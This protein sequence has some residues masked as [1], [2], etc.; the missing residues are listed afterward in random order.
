[1][2]SMVIYGTVRQRYIWWRCKHCTKK[3]Y[4]SYSKTPPQKLNVREC[5][6]IQSRS[7]HIP[8]K[9]L[10]DIKPSEYILTVCNIILERFLYANC[11]PRK[12]F[13][14]FQKYQQLYYLLLDMESFFKV[15]FTRNFW[16]VGLLC[17]CKNNN[18]LT[19]GMH[20]INWES[21]F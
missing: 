7:W 10:D 14:T 1:M 19:G 12:D 2:E 13:E 6:T 16:D 20:R 3:H 21:Q 5:S 17:K 4:K 18:I 15:F 9:L 8:W 11:I